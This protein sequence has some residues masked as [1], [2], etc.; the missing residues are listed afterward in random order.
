MEPRLHVNINN[1]FIIGNKTLKHT[2]HSTF[3]FKLMKKMITKWGYFYIQQTYFFTF[4]RYC[5]V[6]LICSKPIFSL[7]SGAAETSLE[8]FGQTC[9]TSY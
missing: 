8:V 1:M 7:F 6:H 2:K 5:S 3:I 9:C 4:L